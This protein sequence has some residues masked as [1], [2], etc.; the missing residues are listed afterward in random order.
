MKSEIIDE[1]EKEEFSLYIGAVD[2]EHNGEKY[3]AKLG[4]EIIIWKANGGRVKVKINLED[5]IEQGIF[6]LNEYLTLRGEK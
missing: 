4:S 5:E 6:E 2:F 3:C 1:T